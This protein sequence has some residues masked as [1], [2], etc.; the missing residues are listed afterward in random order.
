MAY[1]FTHQSEYDTIYSGGGCMLANLAD[2][3]GMDPFVQ[4]LHDYAQAHWFG[5]T[6]TGDFQAAIEAAAI[7][8]GVVFDSAAYWTHW[9]VDS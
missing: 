2:R 4:V 3:F 1:W 8:D 7:A 6:R 9:R 5:V